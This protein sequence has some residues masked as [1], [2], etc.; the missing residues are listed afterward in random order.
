MW[1]RKQRRPKLLPKCQYHEVAALHVT[2]LTVVDQRILLAILGKPG[3][4]FLKLGQSS[5]SQRLVAQQVV[6]HDQNLT[7]LRKG[8]NQCQ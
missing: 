6:D 4:C 7:E 8:L 2:E 1:Q 5:L 3:V